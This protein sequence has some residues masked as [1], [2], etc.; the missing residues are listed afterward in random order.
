[1]HTA[2]AINR[3]S[4]KQLCI[5][6][7]MTQLETLETLWDDWDNWNAAVDGCKLFRRGRQGRR[8]IPVC[9]RV[10]LLSGARWWDNRIE[11]ECQQSRNP[12][13]SQL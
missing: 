3:R 4:W 6:K 11:G 9:Q 2:Q 5:W 7:S 1:M 12:G 8:D 10:F 13:G